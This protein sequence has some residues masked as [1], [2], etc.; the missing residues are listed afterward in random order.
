MEYTIYTQWKRIVSAVRKI[1][2]TKFKLRRTNQNR[3]MLVSNCVVSG[4]KKSRLTKNQ[5]A[6]NYPIK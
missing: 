4:E 3:L 2:Q 5:E 1:L 6:N